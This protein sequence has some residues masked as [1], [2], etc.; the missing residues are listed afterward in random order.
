MCGNNRL[1]I[2]LL[3]IMRAMM[4]AHEASYDCTFCGSYFCYGTCRDNGVDE[5][6]YG[7]DK[8]NLEVLPTVQA[9]SGPADGLREG[10]ESDGRPTPALPEMQEGLS[11]TAKAY[12]RYRVAGRHRLSQQDF[13]TVRAMEHF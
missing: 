10:Q 5:I 3:S 13:S 7:G 6:F 8:R 9:A 2:S 4:F 11:L 1:D 12:S